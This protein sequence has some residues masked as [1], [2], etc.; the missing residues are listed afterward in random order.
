MAPEG[1]EVIKQ[2]PYMSRGD[3]Q[4]IIDTLCNSSDGKHYIVLAVQGGL[5]A[6]GIDY[7]GDAL[8]GA[9][10]VGPGLPQFDLEREELK[11]YYEKHYGAQQG[12]A[13]AYIYPAMTKVIQAAG[14]VIRTEE[15]R[16]I[17]VLLDDR[18]CDPQ[19]ANLMPSGWYN[20]SVQELVSTKILADV[21]DF[22]SQ[23][24]L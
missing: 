9:M 15:D 7:P 19:Y 22:W 1:F 20:R 16:G 17:I 5:F 6:E 3:A 10:I 8:I 24:A 14:R 12:Y 13:Y 11:N 23:S 21:G 2:T 18:F 4:A